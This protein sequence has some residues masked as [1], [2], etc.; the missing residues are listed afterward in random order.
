MPSSSQSSDEDD[1][2]A[3]R[4]T[5]EYYFSDSSSSNSSSSASSSSSSSSSASSSAS[6]A[7]LEE[8]PHRSNSQRRNTN[9]TVEEVSIEQEDE[10]PLFS[11]QS[12]HNGNTEELPFRSNNTE[13]EEEERDSFY[14]I[15]NVQK[16]ATEEEIRE[17]YRALAIV[18]H[19]DK[20]TSP[21]LK[22]SAEN[23]FRAIQRAY[24]VL[25]D[26]EKRSIYDHFG[27]QGLTQQW[28]LVQRSAAGGPRTAAEMR[29]EWEKVARKKKAEAVENLIRSKGEFIAS[30][31]ASS[32]FCAPERVPR[33]KHVLH[34]VGRELAMREKE[35]GSPIGE[36]EEIEIE[37]PPVSF[38]ERWNRVGVT[39]LTGKHGWETPITGYTRLLF[40][41]Q[42]ASRN[43]MGGGNLIGTLRTQW[44]PKLSTET[45]MTLMRPRVGSFKAT[46]GF[47]EFR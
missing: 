35:R 39:S 20:H 3:P 30:I 7:P 11:N 9:Q 37:L 34:Q 16:D 46:Y 24:E 23:R 45:M 29:E 19:P 28:S 15:L 2:Y 36:D 42:M 14:A 27:A 5:S 17:A 43:G 25:S 26:V 13:E 21:A 12:R 1:P 41:G 10:E 4:S 22:A 31:D 6:S 38:G 44:N 47:N 33:G 32:L 8:I 40:N 18:I